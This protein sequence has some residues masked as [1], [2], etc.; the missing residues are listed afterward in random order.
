[1]LSPTRTRARAR[2]DGGFHRE[3]G[4]GPDA[5][6]N[7]ADTRGSGSAAC[8]ETI[9]PSSRRATT[10]VPAT[11]RHGDRPLNVS[12]AQPMRSTKGVIDNHLKCFG[13]GNLE[14]ILSDYAP[15]AVLFTAEAPRRGIDEIRPLFEDMLAEFGKPGA[16]FRLEHLSVEGDSG[17]I[18]WTAE[19]ADNVYELGTDTFVV[20]NG[21]IVVQSFA[22]KIRAKH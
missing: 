17:Y 10:A 19:T 3:R 14:G 18:L 12:E 5:R 4:A 9:G 21:K 15:D 13:E 6:T 11:W 22:G 16:I 2:P 20:R 8:G 1:L 7:G